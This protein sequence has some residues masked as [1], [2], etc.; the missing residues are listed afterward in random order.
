MRLQQVQQSSG[1]E[2]PFHGLSYFMDAHV[3]RL[4]DRQ[5]LQPMQPMQTG[6]TCRMYA[7]AAPRHVHK[8]K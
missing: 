3:L 7:N 1:V 5:T 8:G 4:L 2:C 6:Q